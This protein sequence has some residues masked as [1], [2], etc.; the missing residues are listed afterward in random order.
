MIFHHDDFAARHE[1][2]IRPKFHRRAG[3]FVELDDGPV[4][5]WSTS[6]MGNWHEPSSTVSVTGIS[7]RMS[8]LGGR[9]GCSY[10]QDFKALRTSTAQCS[11]RVPSRALKRA[12][13]P[14]R[15]CTRLAASAGSES[16]SPTFKDCNMRAVIWGRAIPR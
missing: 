8:R 13:P 3:G 10:N 7:S 2:A 5:S 14:K 16:T 4:A 1:F 6:R 15:S 12:A 9:Q 11:S